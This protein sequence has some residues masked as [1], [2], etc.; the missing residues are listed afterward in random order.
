MA[1]DTVYHRL[2]YS[3]LGTEIATAVVLRDTLASEFEFLEASPEHSYDA[4]SRIIT[5]NLESLAPGDSGEVFVTT[6]IRD[7]IQWAANVLSG[8]LLDCEQGAEC[9]ATHSVTVRAP[10]MD[11]K[12][13]GDTS[14]VLA[15]DLIQYDLSFDNVGDTLATNVVVVDS[16]PKEVTFLSA[17]GNGVY[18][19]TSHSV[20]WFVGDLYPVEPDAGS[21]D[22]LGKTSSGPRGQNDPNSGIDTNFLIEVAV[23]YP[24]P[25]GLQL[26]NT[27]Y[28]YSDE[29]LQ[30]SATWIHTV[31]AHPEFMFTKTAD[32]EVFPG[33]TIN[34]Q[35]DYANVH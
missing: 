26:F 25:N 4:D 20:T 14:Y 34:Y 10:Q 23:N 17:S 2:D 5:W 15:G 22:V 33:D 30:A 13:V 21:S 16:L 6:R 35:L 1:G 7:E 19:S 8:G 12:L 32:L 24:L 11:I 3:N 31:E 29:A 27:A 9:V 28:I 18:D